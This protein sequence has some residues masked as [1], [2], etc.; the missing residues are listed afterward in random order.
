MKY[1]RL[2]VYIRYDSAEI[3]GFRYGLALFTG[4]LKIIASTGA[5]KRGF[6][7]FPS[8]PSMTSTSIKHKQSHSH[9][10]MGPE[11]DIYEGRQRTKQTERQPKIVVDLIKLNT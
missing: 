2:V 10:K 1:G 8:T 5:L 6:S 3:W 7:S 4:T 11:R 9:Q